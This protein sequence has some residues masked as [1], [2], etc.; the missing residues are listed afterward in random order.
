MYR[1]LTFCCT[2]RPHV[3]N[4][5]Q[6][7]GTWVSGIYFR[8]CFDDLFPP[9]IIVFVPVLPETAC[10]SPWFIVYLLPCTSCQIAVHRIPCYRVLYFP[11]LPPARINHGIWANHLT[12]SFNARRSAI[13]TFLFRIVPCNDLLSFIYDYKRPSGKY[14]TLS[15]HNFWHEGFYWPIRDYYS[16][17]VSP[18]YKSM[19]SG[20]NRK[21]KTLITNTPSSL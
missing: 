15:C 21:S 6:P 20:F 18:D 17:F 19:L 5:F 3:L 9:V 16:R 12:E 1:Y 4:C 8:Y 14:R 7:W 2:C 10:L 13:D 11:V